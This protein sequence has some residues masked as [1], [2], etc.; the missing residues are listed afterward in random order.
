MST[1]RRAGFTL[2]EMV[3]AVSIFSLVIGSATRL[4]IDGREFS[5]ATQQ[6][7]NATSSAQRALDRALDELR[8]ASSTVNPD[9][10]TARGSSTIQFQTPVS[11]ANGVVTW[12]GMSQ[13]LFEADPADPLGGGDNDGDGLVDEGRLVLVRNVGAL[14]ERRI[15]LATG[16]PRL[17]PDELLNNIDDDGDGV[18][19]EAG[20]NVVR[21]GELFTLRLVVS[22]PAP[23]GVR[24][25]GRAEASFR[26]RN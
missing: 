7:A 24:Q 23:G 21:V 1:A 3:L 20:F 15:T 6:R 25:I 5:R 14:N 19:D 2:L 12:S 18:I 8:E 26:L 10:A 9:P 16:V 17:D 4:L 13:L 11:V 22:E